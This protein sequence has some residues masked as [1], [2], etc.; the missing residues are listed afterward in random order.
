MIYINF[1]WEP[2]WERKDR[3]IKPCLKMCT[4]KI[5]LRSSGITRGVSMDNPP[6]WTKTDQHS[7]DQSKQSKK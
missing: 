4:Q 6:A 5:N 2:V 7:H 1:R 3:K